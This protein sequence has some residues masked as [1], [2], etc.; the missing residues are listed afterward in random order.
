MKPPLPSIPGV[1]PT[2]S[3]C[4][5][6]MGLSS[7]SPCPFAELSGNMATEWQNYYPKES[8][9]VQG[10]VSKMTAADCA[11]LEEGKSLYAY[12]AADSKIA[13][14]EESFSTSTVAVCV[15]YLFDESGD[16][17]AAACRISTQSVFSDEWTH[18]QKF[19]VH[20][21]YLKVERCGI[22]EAVADRAKRIMKLCLSDLQNQSKKIKK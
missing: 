15:R 18:S 3:L 16:F 12:F 22:S 9:V 20:G 2:T 7:C 8:A 5:A 14:I 4:L 10:C 6:A 11:D 21:Q 17:V 1:I 13:Y 19:L